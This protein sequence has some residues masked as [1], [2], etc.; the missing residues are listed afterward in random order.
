[1]TYQQM[2]FIDG[3]EEK[4]SPVYRGGSR[5]SLTA[6]R[7]S[8]KRL[9][10]NV[11]YGLKCGELLARLTPDGLWQKMYQDCYQVKMDGSLE[12]Y[13]GIL[14]KWGMML[15]GELRALQ[16]LE[17]YID[18]SEWR[19]LPTPTRSDYKGGCLRKNP[20]KQMSNL[21]EHIYTYADTQTHSIYLNPVFL[22]SLMGFPTGWTELNH[23]ET[24]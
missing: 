7:A 6:L 4:P 18:E 19:L 10:T 3:L 20:K 9:L 24:P 23:S 11:T 5:A 8:V 1:M 16:E 13:Y 15:D 2:T 21:K 12:E 22:E 14:P 17:P